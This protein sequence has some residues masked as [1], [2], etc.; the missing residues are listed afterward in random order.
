M[1]TRETIRA[2]IEEGFPDRDVAEM[3]ELLDLYGTE[4]HEK[5]RERVQLAILEL[6]KGDF[7]LLLHNIEAAKRDFRDVLYWAENPTQDG[8]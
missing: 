3:F 5:E 8:V 2:A 7:E 6:S 1:T 4:L